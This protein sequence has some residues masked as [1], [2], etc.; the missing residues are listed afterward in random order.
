MKVALVSEEFP[1]Y[2]IGG[3]GTFCYHL[4]QGLSKKQISTTVYSGR[5]ERLTK[6]KI[7]DYLEIVRLPCLD[8]PPRFLWFQLE[9]FSNITKQLKDCS[10][11]HAISPEV[12][13]ICVYM[14][15]RLGKPLVTSY[16][17]VTRYE[18]KAFL[19]I[20]VSEWTPKEFGFH[21]LGL[22]MY[23]SSNRMSVAFSDHIISCSF[24]V[25]NE[26]RSTYENL[27]LSRSSVIY[28]GI[29]LDEVHKLEKS[30]KTTEN[31][32]SPTLIYYGRLNWLKG[33]SYVMD[34]FKLLVP[35]YPNLTLKMFGEGPLRHSLTEHVA[36]SDFKDKVHIPGQIPHSQLLKE[37]MKADVVVLPSFRE[38]QP[39]SVLEAMAC[40]KPVVV[41]DLPF[42]REY[43]KS[44][45][46]G[47]AVKPGDARDLAEKIDMLLSDRALRLRLGQNAYEHI[48]RNHNWNT[49]IDRYIDVYE[50]VAYAS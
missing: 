30:H 27:D 35:N 20:P 46:N 21:V 42:A 15:H 24:A 43:V 7:N 13:P 44:S 22:P 36:S 19:N 34:A 8:F 37:I 18:L 26:L 33:V 4:A 32:D 28:N 31:S 16:H 5:A 25:L 48:R 3:A 47:M 29:N 45:V 1:P 49:L 39:F 50:K 17:G 6:E 41:F 40:K 11:I 9:N 23:W 12:S 38:A 14:K 2:I 10:V